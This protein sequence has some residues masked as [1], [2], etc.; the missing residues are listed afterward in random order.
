MVKNEFGG[1]EQR[2]EDVFDCGTAGRAFGVE[3]GGGDLQL[4]AV[5]RLIDDAEIAGV[6]GVN[7]AVWAPNADAVS[8]IGDFNHWSGT[9]AQM[10]VLGSTW[11]SSRGAPSP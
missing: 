6:E 2:P 3:G 10:R 8:V 11:F 1:V 5:A 4:G 7:F 9:E